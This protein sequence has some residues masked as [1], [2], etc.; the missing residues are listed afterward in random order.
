MVGAGRGER[1]IVYGAF[2]A[3]APRIPKDPVTCSPSIVS[4]EKVDPARERNRSPVS[5]RPGEPACLNPFS[6]SAAFNGQRQREDPVMPDLLAIFPWRLVREI[7]PASD[8]KMI[9]T[10]PGEGSGKPMLI[11]NSRDS[12]VPF[13]RAHRFPGREGDG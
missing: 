7:G 2:E 1:R 5:K 12:Q 6:R 4:A 9:L 11:R 13:E 10:G 3:A 8:K